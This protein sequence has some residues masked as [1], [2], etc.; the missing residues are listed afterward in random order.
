MKKLQLCS[1]LFIFV[2]S[3]CCYGDVQ[4]EIDSGW[5]DMYRGNFTQARGIITNI[6][7][8][9]ASS[10][11]KASANLRLAWVG[12][13]EAIDNGQYAQAK[14]MVGSLKTQYA[15]NASLGSYILRTAERME[16][17]DQLDVAKELYGDAKLLDS[18]CSAKAT[19][20]ELWMTIFQQIAAGNIDIA[21]NAA[22]QAK[23]QF[24]S[25][26][27]LPEMIFRVGERLR[28]KAEYTKA[29]EFY[30]KS[31]ELSLA[32]AF[33]VQSQFEF[34]WVDTLMKIDGGDYQSAESNVNEML[35]NF[36]DN[37]KMAEALYSFAERFRWIGY[38]SKVEDI[39]QKIIQQYSGSEVAGKANLDVAVINI[40]AM[41]EPGNENQAEAALAGLESSLSDTSQLNEAIL[42][43]GE[44]YY[45][46]GCELDVQGQY[47]LAESY[48]QKSI[49]LW[50]K[51]KSRVAAS[52]IE[53]G[54]WDWAGYCYKNTGQ[55]DKSVECFKK[56]Y[57]L[58][59]DVSPSRTLLLIGQNY[60]ALRD[61]SEIKAAYGKIVK[62]HPE[63][64]AAKYARKWLK[65]QTN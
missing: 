37:N 33:A 9:D 43:A 2:I 19:W 32:G 34:L 29:K 30:S 51:V 52:A 46:K 25:H 4:S 21:L 40:L 64:P 23:T 53:P 3:L 27:E 15:G 13:F 16:W 28:W 61:S 5:Q 44:Q 24:S 17:D 22:N 41:I 12:V 65:G 39:Y 42:L 57:E 20:R 59:P 50:I 7:S 38:Y 49:S 58:Y 62:L 45:L 35:A 1:L 31:I 26:A 11:D 8:S 6:I 63:T 55:F 60:E 10:A 54:F 14:T 18:Q 36:S 48:F 56:K 47:A